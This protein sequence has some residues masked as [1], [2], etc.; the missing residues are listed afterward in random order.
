[1]ACGVEFQPGPFWLRVRL[2]G[3]GR[4][5]ESTLAAW[6]SIAGEVARK[7]PSALRVASEVQG[8]AGIR[9][10]HGER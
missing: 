10:R 2:T 4:D 8:A 9:L 3:A 6:R 7:R 5:L 1:M